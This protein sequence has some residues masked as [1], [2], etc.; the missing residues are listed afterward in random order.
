MANAVAWIGQDGN[1]WYK[2]PSGVQNWGSAN[3]YKFTNGGISA[4]TAGSPLAEGAGF[5]PGV[6]QIQDPALATAAPG[7]STTNAPL[8]QAAIDNT[9]SSIAQI[10]GLLQAALASENNK[11]ANAQ[12]AFNAQEAQQRGQYGTS[13]T[14]NQQN[15]DANFMDAIRAGIKG[16]HGLFQLLRGTGAA[17]GTADDQVRNVVGATTASDVGAGANTFKTNQDQ[18]DQS[19]GQFLTELSGK[20]QAA[21]D[22]HTN[23]VS[24]INRDSNSNLQDLYSKMAGF[25]GNAGDTAEANDWM[26]KAGALI[27]KIAQESKSVTSKFDTTPI[28]VH[29][30]NLTAFAAPRQPAVATAP[31]DG[32]VGS[33]I[34]A[35]AAPRDRKPDQT[36][37]PSLVGA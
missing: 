5:A 20:R 27:P 15:Y 24:A 14:T 11:F 17:G 8:D 7:P 31:Q 34:F 3:Q 19:L 18:L 35:L 12:N 9:N 2:G 33:G 36:Q 29:A 30:P 32:Q 26:A 28:V 22:T 10:P 25:Y 6:D 4:V 1:L 37:V 23:N 21:D 13:S 16:L